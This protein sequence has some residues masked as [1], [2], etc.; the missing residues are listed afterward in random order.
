MMA[1]D[2]YCQVVLEKYYIDLYCHKPHMLFVCVCA[3]VCIILIIIIAF[4]QWEVKKE[5][6]VCYFT[7]YFK[8]SFI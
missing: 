7:M 1:L 4:F 6:I 5:A 8:F 3:C 2:L